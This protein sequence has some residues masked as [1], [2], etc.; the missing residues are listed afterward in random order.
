MDGPPSVPSTERLPFSLWEQVCSSVPAALPTGTRDSAL[1]KVWVHVEG[2]VIEKQA[3]LLG[4]AE[5]YLHH[6]FCV[7]TN[8]DYE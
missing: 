3:S 6:R 8:G 7:Q 1:Q 2:F 5:S 4:A